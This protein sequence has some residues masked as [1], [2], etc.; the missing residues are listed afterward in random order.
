[1][2]V[3]LSSTTF[4]GFLI[5]TVKGALAIEESCFISTAILLMTCNNST[6]FF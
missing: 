3:Y 4:L 2:N 6:L 1:M 5:G